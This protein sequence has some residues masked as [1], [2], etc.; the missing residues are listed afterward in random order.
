MLISELGGSWDRRVGIKETKASINN[1]TE[2]I[3]SCK[4]VFWKYMAKL[5]RLN[6][7]KG[8]KIV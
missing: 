6:N 2:A 8:K 7:S 4:S 3:L 5:I 1:E